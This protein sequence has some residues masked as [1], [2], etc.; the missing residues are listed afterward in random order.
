MSDITTQLASTQVSSISSFG[1]E[2]E[3]LRAA[4]IGQNSM[5]EQTLGEGVAADRAAAASSSAVVSGAAGTRQ[6]LAQLHH[7]RQ[8]TT[9]LRLKLK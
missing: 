9:E 8:L 2:V 7:H 1:S 5:S 4:M 3:G 6:S